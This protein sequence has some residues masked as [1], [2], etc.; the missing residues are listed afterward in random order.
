MKILHINSYYFE[1][2]LYK[3]LYDTQIEKGH[4]IVVYV[5]ALK[6]QKPDF[7]HGDYTLISY[8]MKKYMRFFFRYKQKLI[9]KDL[10]SK[11]DLSSFDIVHA[12][13][14]FT[15]GYLAYKIKK[16]FGIDYICNLQNTD[17]NLFLRYRWSLFLVANKIIKL[18]REIVF[19]SEIY[20]IRTI[21]LLSLYF[22]KNKIQKSKVIPIG[23]DNY[24]LKNR[25]TKHD[26]ADDELI[27]VQ[28]GNV[29]KNKN[30]MSS[31]KAIKLL[32]E[33]GYNIKFIIAG[34]IKSIR[35]FKKIQSYNFIVYAGF[36]NKLQLLQLFNVSQIFLMPSLHETFGLVYAEAI[37]QSVPIVYSKNEGFDLQFEDGLVGLPVNPKNIYEISSA[38]EKI[39]NNIN[40]YFDIS[41]YV[42]KFDWNEITES[43]T[44]LYEYKSIL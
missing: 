36:L 42:I 21:R 23:I 38:I 15:N 12:H 40:N 20:K 17:L 19:I 14:L 18:S 22:S 43:Y 3:N 41:K 30:Q 33:N 32:I 29:N 31:I 39:I 5:P 24:W 11:L 13:T 28:A 4:E 8:C 1:S 37:S 9:Y 16:E 35:L 6:N 10:K 2:S 44:Q 34:K 7:D 25:K 26:P 27:I